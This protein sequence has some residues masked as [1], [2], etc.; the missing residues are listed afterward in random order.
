[1][2]NINPVDEVFVDEISREDALLWLDARRQGR[3]VDLMVTVWTV[4]TTL[5]P[6]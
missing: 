5:W 1:M 6:R 3:Y 2:Q 4:G